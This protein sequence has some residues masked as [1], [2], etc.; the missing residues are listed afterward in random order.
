MSKKLLM[1]FMMENGKSANVTVQD[2]KDGITEK[3]IKDVMDMIVEKKALR[4]K[5]GT[6]VSSKEAVIVNTEKEMFDL[7]LEDE[8]EA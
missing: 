7:V 8:Q 1:K 4:N 5:N 3:E 2:P 6:V